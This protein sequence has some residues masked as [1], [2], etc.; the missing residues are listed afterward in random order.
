MRERW[1]P[2]ERTAVASHFDPLA[3]VV[4]CKPLEKGLDLEQNPPRSNLRLL[5]WVDQCQFAISTDTFNL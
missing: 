4:H 2:N 3:D 5:V 1:S